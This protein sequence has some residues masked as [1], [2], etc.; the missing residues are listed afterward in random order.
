MEKK[1]KR[2]QRKW[3]K[4]ELTANNKGIN[5]IDVKT[6]RH[7]NVKVAGLHEKGFS[8]TTTQNGRDYEDSLI[9]S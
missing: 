8:T 5:L 3:P 2:E 6:I 7:K 4:R 9:D 1:L